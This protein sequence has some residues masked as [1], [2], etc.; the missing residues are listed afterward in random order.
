[1]VLR[2]F[3][4]QCNVILH[5]ITSCTL[6]QFHLQCSSKFPLVCCGF[7]LLFTLFF[8]DAAGNEQSWLVEIPV[9]RSIFECNIQKS[10]PVLSQLKNIMLPLRI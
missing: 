2:D 8:S 7:C 3:K 5:C 1:M 6:K 9:E 4:L 10:V